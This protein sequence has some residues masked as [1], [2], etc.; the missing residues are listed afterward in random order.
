M[1]V[2]SKTFLLKVL[3]KFG[4]NFDHFASTIV[5]EIMPWSVFSSKKPIFRINFEWKYTDTFVEIDNILQKVVRDC[6]ASCS[7]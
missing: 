2:L 4:F 1:L 3:M 5:N 6:T 7:F